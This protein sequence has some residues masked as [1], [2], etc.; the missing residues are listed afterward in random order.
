MVAEPLLNLAKS[1]VADRLPGAQFVRAQKVPERLFGFLELSRG[2]IAEW[3]IGARAWH[4]KQTTRPARL[5]TSAICAANVCAAPSPI[6]STTPA[7]LK[8][9]STR[10]AACKTRVKCGKCGQRRR[11]VDVRPNLE[12]G[13]NVASI[14]AVPRPLQDLEGEPGECPPQPVGQGSVALD[15]CARPETLRAMS[16][17]SSPAA[18]VI[19]VGRKQSR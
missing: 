7:D 4:P 3:P 11:C 10:R 9:L 8:R 19:I 13:A 12:G 1:L 15:T 5:W 6:A 17:W 16:R 14:A 2:D 18:S